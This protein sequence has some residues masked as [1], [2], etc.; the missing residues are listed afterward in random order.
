MK[1]I[2]SLDQGTTSSRA[3]LFDQNGQMKSVAQKEFQ[4]Y[5]PQPGWVEHDA[6]EIWETQLSVARDA[7]AKLGISAREIAAIG[8][9]NQRETTILWEKATGRPIY[10]AIVWQCRRTAPLVDELLSQPG[11]AEYIKEN[12]GLVPDAYFSATKIKWILDHVPEINLYMEYADKS[13]LEEVLRLFREN[14][15]SLQD[16]EIT[17]ASGNENHNACAIFSLRFSKGASVD[18][19][20]TQVTRIDG[21]VSVQEL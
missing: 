12:T 6:L 2:L 1:Y 4:Q 17:R 20:L 21:V 10:N 3:I 14:R 9:T 7:I 15:V 8:I 16:M 18:D 19:L 13:S 5:Y 11:M